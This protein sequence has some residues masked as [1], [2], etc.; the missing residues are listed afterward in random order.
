MSDLS[1]QL[2]ESRG[3]NE[4][5]LLVKKA[6]YRSL[7]RRRVGLMLGLADLP[8]NLAAYYTPNIIVLNRRVVDK[9]RES[10]GGGELFNSYLFQILLHEYLHSLGYD[11][12]YAEELGYLVCRE[13]LGEEHP[14]T[15]MARYGV[16]AV[17]PSLKELER[18]V[19][20]ITRVQ[21]GKIELVKGFD[22]ENLTYLT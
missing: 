12:E 20:D 7:G 6:V 4:V 14:A 10:S 1:K 13:N 16:S 9:V 8:S 22:S 3:F 2:D 5:F 19:E 18:G 21:P 15:L 17:V 11:E